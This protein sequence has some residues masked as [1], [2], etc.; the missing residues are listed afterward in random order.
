[1]TLDT[2]NP[3]GQLAACTG[4][5]T[6]VGSCAKV[7]NGTSCGPTSCSGSNVTGQICDGNGTCTTQTNVP[8][9]PYTC[10]G[11]KCTSPCAG[12]GDCASGY[13]C[14]NPG[15]S[16]TC[17]AKSGPSLGCS[18]ADQCTTSFCSPDGVCCDSPC[19]GQCESCSEPGS[20]GACK[21]VSGSPRTGH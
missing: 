6:G 20:L 15:S 3:C 13:Y 12:D 7:P 5:G 21:T 9:A 4:N 18:A 14:S 8:C 16:G 10:S 2:T 11:S 17:V 19:N 1:C